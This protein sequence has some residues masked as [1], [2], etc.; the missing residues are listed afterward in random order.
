[1]EK[2]DDS[3]CNGKDRKDGRTR[4]DYKPNNKWINLKFREDLV[5]R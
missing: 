3:D 4:R 2:L 5:E 1:M